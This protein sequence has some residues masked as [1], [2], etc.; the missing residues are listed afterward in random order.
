MKHTMYHLL[1]VNVRPRTEINIPNINFV[2]E[3]IQKHFLLSPVLQMECSSQP[4]AHT[5][6]EIFF[7]MKE[8]ACK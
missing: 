6:K 3:I 5:G 4:D 1:T 7:L 2:E 8:K